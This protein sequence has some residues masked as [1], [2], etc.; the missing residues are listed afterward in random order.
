[1]APAS[2]LLQLCVCVG[3]IYTS[4][5]LYGV[6]QE[7]LYRAQPDGTTFAATAFVLMTQCFINLSVSLVFDLFTDGPLGKLT[8]H[9]PAGY[10]WLSTLLTRDVAL[11]SLVYVMAMYMSNEALQYVTYPTQALAKSCKMI[12]VLLGRVL[13]LRTSYSW[14][15][16]ACVL[17]MTAGIAMFQLSGKKKMSVE[18]FGGEGF[19]MLLLAISLALDGITGPMQE[20][21]KKHKLSN[22]QQIIVNNVWATGLMVAVAAWQGQLT[23][24]VSYLVEHPDLMQLL[25][26]FG[27]CSAFGQI[28]IFYTIRTFDS[29]TLSTITT[30]RKFFT[31]IVSVFVHGHVLL[32]QQWVAVTVVFVGLV[33]EVVDSENEKRKK[34][35]HG[36]LHSAASVGNA[37]AEALVASSSVAGK[38][39]VGSGPAGKPAAGK[40]HTR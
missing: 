29:L 4:Y 38:E 26:L 1:M 33:L 31:I 25:V 21:L 32:S 35:H 22:N 39:R 2:R 34:R 10:S 20:Q 27:L 8:G 40:Q 28:F 7:T 15:K 13:F 18:G 3:G 36:H 11:T 16:Y 30:T 23:Y 6:F 17:L 19:G 12:P 24:G 5:I 9:T 14:I 37:P